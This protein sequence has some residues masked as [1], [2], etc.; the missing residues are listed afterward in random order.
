[1]IIADLTYLV[2][3]SDLQEVEGGQKN[4]YHDNRAAATAYSYADDSETLTAA[5][6]SVYVSRGFSRAWS[7]SFL[8]L[9]I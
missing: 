8:R 7:R 2:V 3:I 4:N 1:M 9:N 5:E 6:T